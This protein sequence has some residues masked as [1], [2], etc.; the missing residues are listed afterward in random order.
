MC[1][2]TFSTVDAHAARLHL[3][4][5]ETQKL[6]NWVNLRTTTRQDPRA[7]SP[8]KEMHCLM[9]I[10]IDG[11]YA[12]RLIFEL[13]VVKAPRACEIFRMLCT[14][15]LAPHCAVLLS[16]SSVPCSTLRSLFNLHLQSTAVGNKT[17]HL[18][19]FERFPTP[20]C[21]GGTRALRTRLALRRIVI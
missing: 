4:K 14:G 18:I 5:R 21:R 8:V 1:D 7:W 15:A 17:P 3:K 13:F 6:L 20:C 19:N 12:G 11:E 2:S 9:D 10:E 16:L